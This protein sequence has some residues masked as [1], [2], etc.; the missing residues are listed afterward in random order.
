MKKYIYSAI[1]IAGVAA[2]TSCDDFLETSSPSVVDADFV[3]SN[4]TTARGAMDGAYEVW[5]D[6]A[7]NAF[8]GDGLFYAADVAGSDIERHPEAFTNQPGRHYPESFYQNGTYASSY[9]LLS[10]LKEGGLYDKGFSVVGKANSVI[11][12]MESSA[13]FDEIVTNAT[14]P[15]P[16]SQMYGE[17]IAMRATA[18]RELIRYWGDVPFSSKFGEVAMG[19]NSR[20][21]IYDVIIADLIRVEP[22]MY[23]VGA[24]PGVDATKKNY[25]SK[26]YVDGLIGRLCLEAGGYQT[27]RT[28]LG[29]D[30]YKDGEGKVLS[31]EKLGTDHNGATYGRRSDWKRFYETAKIYFKKAIDNPGTAKFYTTDP[32]PAEKNGRTYDNPYQ[33][34]FQQMH[35]ADAAY[36]D[37]SIYEYAQ[38]QGGGN[39]GRPYSFGRPSSGGSKNAY[40]CK[41]Y[42]QGRIN[43]AYY[44]GI[45]DPNDKRRDVSVCVTGSDGKGNEKLISFKG[46]SKADAGGLTLNKWDE[47]RQNIPWVAAQRKSGINGP[48]MRMAEMY[49]GYAEA[50]AATND[51]ANALQALRT[52]RERSF[53]AGEAKT[54]EFVARCGRDTYLNSDECAQW[55]T[56]FKAIIEERG[57]EFAGEGDRRWTIIR[58]GLVGGLIHRV[59]DMTKYMLDGLKT[60]G[61]YTFDNGNT[62]SNYVWTKMV[63][64]KTQYGY[65]LTAECQ[66]VNDPV[67]YPGWRGQNDAWEDWGCKYGANPKTNLA[68][69]GLFSFIDPVGAEAAALEA[70]GYT[71]TNWAVDIS[72]QEYYQNLFLDYDYKSAPIYLWPFTPNTL[73]TGGF[74]NG[75]GFTNE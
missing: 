14:E 53:R 38:Q 57:F 42:G 7:Q 34:F 40:P 17:A 74:T 71:K 70:D 60:K 73:S 67:L 30:F 8:F 65:R 61:L 3:F 29:A 44:Y 2:M 55:S 47:N 41:S 16:L 58:T 13:N 33:Y 49:L 31:F 46:G 66:N 39:D 15:S 4:P 63:D 10:Y 6:A 54:D 32:R 62:I 5:R 52:V 24:I 21:S 23:P 28:D 20:D 43:P 68:I 56:L 64:A 35:E 27:R 12:A 37:E 19:I 11:T 69:K 9:P 50:C 72:E 26:T 36:A 1:C 18:Y 75:Y 22:L 51:E 48:Y 25:F 45:F 59:K